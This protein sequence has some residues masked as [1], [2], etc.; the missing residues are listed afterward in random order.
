MDADEA[1]A[2]GLI[3]EVAEANLQEALDA[4]ISDWL[5]RPVQAMI[6]TKKI[7]ADMHRPYLLKILELEKHSQQK[8]RETID[9]QE[10]IKAFIEKD[11]PNL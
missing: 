6:K 10:G 9:H 7:L 4:R 2:L 1:F 8:M 3:E 5:S 11:N